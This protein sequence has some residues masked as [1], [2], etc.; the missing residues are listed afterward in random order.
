MG[1][2]FFNDRRM[3]LFMLLPFRC[4]QS[5]CSLFAVDTI[6]E[7]C[8]LERSSCGRTGHMRA[9]IIKTTEKKRIPYVHGAFAQ[10]KATGHKLV[11]AHHR[12]S[13]LATYTPLLSAVPSFAT[14]STALLPPAD[15]HT[16][17][18]PGRRG[19]WAPSSPRLVAPS[20]AATTCNSFPIPS[21]SSM[22]SPR[23]RPRQSSG[24]LLHGRGS[25]RR[26]SWQPQPPVQQMPQCPPPPYRRA[27]SASHSG[28]RNSTSLR[29][30]R[31]RGH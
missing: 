24:G 21:G 27:L 6:P 30:S 8:R 2:C 11:Q 31:R 18:P 15:A 5:L 17:Q 9:E 25:R 10:K 19:S 1:W 22:D 13:P 16:P 14:T 7:G 29:P 4:R 12:Q 23:S 20:A 26:H 28:R 3:A